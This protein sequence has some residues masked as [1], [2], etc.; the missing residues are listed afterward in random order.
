MMHVCIFGGTTEGRLLAVFLSEFNV[1]ADLYIATEYGEQFVKDL[2]NVNVH[3]KRLDKQRMIE[4]FEKNRFDCVADAT[5]PFAKIV[6][7]NV[8][9]A[10][11]H[12]NLKYYRIVRETDKNEY[13][14]YFDHIEDI[15]SHLNNDEGSIL[16]TTGSKDLDKFIAVNNYKERI[17]VRILPM[18]SSLKKAV[19]LGYSNKNII[20]MQ[21]P[22]SEELNI[23]MMN[24]IGAKFMVT[25]E[26]AASGGFEE[27]VNACI[28]T[29]A[30]CLVLKMA[31]EEGIT[32]K[33]FKQIIRGKI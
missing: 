30:K 2:N 1:K 5:H 23:A 21:G 11:E 33:D 24:S 15:I 27:K 28:K 18:E 29:N 17:F 14:M 7:Q 10:A 25:K 32:L 3:Q 16:L 9:E 26:S 13:P 31:E 22:F 12:C 6:S 4:L 20:C 19:E 8:K